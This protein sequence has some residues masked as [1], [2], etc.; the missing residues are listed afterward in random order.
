MQ[1]ARSY[2]A[3]PLSGL[4]AANNMKVLATND[5]SRASSTDFEDCDISDVENDTSSDGGSTVREINAQLEDSNTEWKK[6][7]GKKR[8]RQ[9][10]GQNRTPTSTESKRGR[11]DPLIFLYAKS[12]EFNIAKEA[13][14]QPTCFKRK[15]TKMFGEVSGIK[16]LKHCIRITCLSEKQKSKILETTE[17]DN[18]V[19]EVTEPW[20]KTSR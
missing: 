4:P 20:K 1:S 15:L 3:Q 19:M 11:Q 13:I 12:T 14:S 9:I 10:S 18:K 7:G 6:A 16:V 8:V 2:K 17:W 5:T